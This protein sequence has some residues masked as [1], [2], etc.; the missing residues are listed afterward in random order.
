MKYRLPFKKETASDT[1]EPKY[2][3]LFGENVPYI[4]L[5]EV[6]KINSSIEQ[7]TEKIIKDFKLKEDVD[8]LWG[9]KGI[10]SMLFKGLN[11]AA[12]KYSEITV[13][14]LKS[15]LDTDKTKKNILELETGSGWSVAVLWNTI[16]MEKPGKLFAIDSSPFSIACTSL[17][18][19]YLDIPYVV[20]RGKSD[21]DI[22]HFEGVVLILRDFNEGVKIVEDNSLD[23]AYSAHGTA[24]LPYKLNM[25]LLELLAKKMKKDSV[26]IT[27]SLTPDVRIK[28]SKFK[29]MKNVIR[30]NNLKRTFQ[31]KYEYYE[32]DGKKIITELLD[33]PA[34][35]FMDF[36]HHLL[37]TNPGTFIG[38]MK[39]ISK[40]EAT[41]QDLYEK[42]RTPSS[43]YYN[44]EFKSDKFKLV[45]V[46]K[47]IR[48]KLPVFVE[49]ACLKRTN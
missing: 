24:Y 26:Y 30:G 14:W 32:K 43:F 33:R 6:K 46:P 3:E 49:T 9:M 15:L 23:A 38:Y 8:P 5:S 48:L 22:K 44:Q 41:Q 20:L 31:N 28:L 29:I 45:A 25:N 47:E 10:S 1:K 40:S 11:P 19:D 27:D 36:L 7:R 34:K 17:M 13:E 35:G 4:P 12:T 39:S 16:M 2:K 21:E 42:V 37:F 18:L